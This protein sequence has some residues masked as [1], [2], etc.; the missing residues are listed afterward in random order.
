MYVWIVVLDSSPSKPADVGTIL[1]V[2]EHVNDATDFAFAHEH[3]TKEATRT[4]RA[5]VQGP[6]S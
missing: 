4:Q 6:S 3:T 5:Q 1:G 2:F